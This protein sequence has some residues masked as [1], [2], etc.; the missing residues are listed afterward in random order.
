MKIKLKGFITSKESE[1]YSD[2]ADHYAFSK[3]N[4][5]FAISDGVSRSFFPKF[6]S[7]ILVEKYVE[8]ETWKEEDFIQYSQ[9]H[10][11][12]EVDEIVKSPD[13]MYFTRNA[14]NRKTPGLATFVGLQFLPK[15]K[16]W[17]AQALG[18]SF[19]FFVPKDCKDFDKDTIKLSSKDEPFV[20][21]NYPD[22][23][24]SIGDLHK[25]DSRKIKGKEL[26]DGT[27]YLMTDALA[28]WFL[29]GKGIENAITTIENIKSQEQFIETIDNERKANRLHNDDSALLIIE[30]SNTRKQKVSFSEIEVSN[31]ESLI[32]I[33]SKE[34]EKEEKKKED[35]EKLETSSNSSSVAEE[36]NQ[37]NTEPEV[38]ENQGGVSESEEE[39]NVPQEEIG[40]QEEKTSENTDS[41]I[42]ENEPEKEEKETPQTENKKKQDG[43][44]EKPQSI[45]DKF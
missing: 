13:T 26:K 14:Y 40:K 30:I 34:I 35:E 44:E 16:K 21:D 9:E 45:I 11:Q 24:S 19:L 6:W 39:N 23:L 17:I 25:G 3:E 22:Y 10:W 36:N 5:K 42:K 29:Q 4:L 41:A 37:E 31:L 15:E 2:C 27:F 43:D 33:Q 20:F 7:R 38:L 1:L 12:N 8:K 32:E 28:E 18:D